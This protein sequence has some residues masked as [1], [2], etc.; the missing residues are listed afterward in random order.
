MSRPLLRETRMPAV[1][2]EIGPATVVVEQAPT[3]ARS[4]VEALALVGGDVLGLRTGLTGSEPSTPTRLFRTVSEAFPGRNPQ[5]HTQVVE[6]ALP[7]VQ[8]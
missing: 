7:W 4:V 3:I 8:G 1:I 5:L 2:C 6:Y